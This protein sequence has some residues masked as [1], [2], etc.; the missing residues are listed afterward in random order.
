[1]N[2]SYDYYP[3]IGLRKVK[4]KSS[5]RQMIE[6]VKFLNNK[7]IVSRYDYLFQRAA[8]SNHYFHNCAGVTK[9][10][11][12][13]YLSV[14]ILLRNLCLFIFDI[15]R[16]SSTRTLLLPYPASPQSH[17]SHSSAR[18]VPPGIT[19]LQSPSRYHSF[20][21]SLQVTRGIT[22]LQSPCRYHGFTESLQ[23]SRI[24]KVPPGITIL[25]FTESL[26]V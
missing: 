20:R 24:Y 15:S 3:C 1:M 14:N 23:V 22:D 6:Q 7:G 21:E 9:N 16:F 18:R 26:Q 19:D 13:W 5:C 17:P 11:I 25:N 10:F 2:F 4:K 12:L 8:K